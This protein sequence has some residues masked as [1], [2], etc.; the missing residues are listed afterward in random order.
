MGVDSGLPDF[1]GPQG[2][3]RASPVFHG[4]H[5]EEISNP[6][7][8]HKDPEQ[9]WG[10]FG[11]RFNLYRTTAPHAGFAILRRWGEDCPKGDF[12]FTSNVDGQF[13]QAGIESER[14]LE[15]H[16]SVHYFQC[17]RPCSETIWSAEATTVDVDA[18][19]IR[20]CPPLP[21]CPHCGGLARPNVLM[22]GDG[23]WAPGRYEDREGDYQKWLAGIARKRLV[24]LE[25]GAGTAVPTVR[26]ECERRGGQLIRVNPRDKDAPPGS[27]VL[28][29]GALQAIQT[30]DKM[31]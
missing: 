15:C 26:W 7:W 2:F 8:F 17:V 1:R 19:T 22:F 21:R 9:A 20:A 23:H 14:V 31:V 13:Q 3:W 18:D 16:G 12:V 28:S 24:V 30:L 5:F 25:F 10:F 6:V 4:H 11:Q 29:T 27:I